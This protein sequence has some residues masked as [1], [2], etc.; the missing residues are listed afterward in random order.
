MERAY[1]VLEGMDSLKTL[2]SSS[3]LQIDAIHTFLGGADGGYTLKAFNIVAEFLD[4]I[5]PFEDAKAKEYR[6]ATIQ[7]LG[8]LWEDGAEARFIKYP[9]EFSLHTLIL[10][11]LPSLDKMKLL[12]EVIHKQPDVNKQWRRSRWTPLHLAVQAGNTEVVQRLFALGVNEARLDLHGHV[13]NFYVDSADVKMLSL[14]ERDTAKDD[15]Q[16]RHAQG[17]RDLGEGNGAGL[18]INMQGLRI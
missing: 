8:H 2:P 9:N 13:P 10:L 14:F 6:K 12:E 11:D 7:R 3:R 16:E 18:I 17:P 15:A 1:G 5:A 4:D